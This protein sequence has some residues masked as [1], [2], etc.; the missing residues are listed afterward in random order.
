[1]GYPK[2]FYYLLWPT[3]RV[4]LVKF[5]WTAAS[6]RPWDRVLL[7][8]CRQRTEP[9]H[10]IN[11]PIIDENI[12]WD[13]VCSL[14]LPDAVLAVMISKLAG[15][16][17]RQFSRSVV[18]CLVNRLYPS[19]HPCVGRIFIIKIIHIVKNMELLVI[20]LRIVLPLEGRKNGRNGRVNLDRYV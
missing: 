16:Y 7:V 18:G 19:P 15:W 3:R 9:K 8:F 1:M 13:A 17:V 2:S 5:R 14:V 12:V 6:C 4:Q 11:V 20:A 10:S